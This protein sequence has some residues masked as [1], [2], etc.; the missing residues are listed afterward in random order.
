MLAQRPLGAASVLSIQLPEIPPDPFAAIA[1]GRGVEF[2]VILEITGFPKAVDLETG[3]AH[4]LLGNALLGGFGLPGESILPTIT[5]ETLFLSDVPYRTKPDDLIRPNLWTEARMTRRADVE[6]SAPVSQGASRRSQETTG[7][8]EFA[9]NDGFLR[10][11]SDLLSFEGRPA[12]VHLAQIGQPWASVTTISQAV[13]KSTTRSDGSFR[14]NLEDASNIIDTPLV[15]RVYQGTGLRDGSPDLEGK[16]PPYGW[17]ECK[18]AKP[19]LEDPSIYLYRLSDSAINA[20]HLVEEAGIEFAFDEDVATYELLRL[21]ADTL[22]EGEYATCLADGSIVIKF[23]GGSPGDPDAIRATFE[24]DKSSGTY[25]SFIGDVFLAMLQYSMGISDSRIDV[26]S[27]QEL[28]QEKISYY[29]GGGTASP[30]GA[31]VFNEIMESAFGTFGSVNSDRIG[32]K[33]FFPPGDQAAS[34]SLS[35]EEIYAADEVEPPQ[36]AIWSQSMGWGPNQNPYTREQ[37]A[38]GSLTQSEIEERTREFEGVYKDESATVLA[39][40]LRSI[41][42]SQISGVFDEED[43]AIDSVQRL[44]G[45]WGVNS[46]TFEVEAAFTA[47]DIR[48]GSVISMTHPDFGD[49]TGGKFLVYNKRLQLSKRRVLLTVV[50]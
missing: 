5:P 26:L 3:G 4:P 6:Q 15:T 41:V 8:L 7:D 12:S 16:A 37:L 20:V 13:V 46:K 1:S 2:A 25:V 21:K 23:A 40:N 49:K 44:M 35:V 32:V 18:F 11:K 27:Y 45:V 9:D 47:A 10:G 48:R 38:V 50:G 30:T 31:Q 19:L 39:S 42:G 22:E 28:P 17:G 43:A 29:F 36:R 14:V 33:L 34:S 24:G